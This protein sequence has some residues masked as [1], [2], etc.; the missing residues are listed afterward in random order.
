MKYKLQ[1]LFRAAASVME[2]GAN[3]AGIAAL[4]GAIYAFAFPAEV[5]NYAVNFEKLVYE[6][7]QDV[8]RIANAAESI[9][10][11]TTTTAQNTTL[12]ANAIPNWVTFGEGPY[13]M[14]Y[15]IPETPYYTS[16]SLN[17]MSPF[18]ISLK[19]T[20]LKEEKPLATKEALIMPGEET[21]FTVL[22]KKSLTEVTYCL[23]GRSDAFSGQTLYERRVYHEFELR[24]AKQSFEAISGC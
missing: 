10:L 15:P 18:Q 13:E 5:A 22:S 14:V 1:N 8:D 11:N 17:N 9:D 4:L 3:F 2:F 19:I 20:A 24:A 16:V 6:A 7:R 21:V 12:L 23:E